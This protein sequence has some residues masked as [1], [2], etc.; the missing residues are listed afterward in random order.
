MDL[1]TL[2]NA[3]IQDSEVLYYIRRDCIAQQSVRKRVNR[4]RLAEDM[5]IRYQVMGIVRRRH[6]FQSLEGHQET[7]LSGGETYLHYQW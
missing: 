4:I 5:C 3:W 6:R 7:G 2:D 1:V